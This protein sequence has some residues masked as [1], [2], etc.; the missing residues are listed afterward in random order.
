VTERFTWVPLL[1]SVATAYLAPAPVAPEIVPFKRAEAVA[2]ALDHLFLPVRI[3]AHGER[4]RHRIADPQR[5][6][7]L[8]EQRPLG[9]NITRNQASPQ[10]VR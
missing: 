6:L 2:V 4:A 1:E 8:M 9:W 7:D 10:N 5:L 3:I